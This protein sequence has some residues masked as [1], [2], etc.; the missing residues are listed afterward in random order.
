MN[1]CGTYT[2]IR[3]T[4]RNSSKCTTPPAHKQSVNKI[5]PSTA[6]GTSSERKHHWHHSTAVPPQINFSQSNISTLH[7]ILLHSKNNVMCSERCDLNT[8]R[9]NVIVNSNIS[10]PAR[11]PLLYIIWR[12]SRV[13][14]RLWME[15]WYRQHTLYIHTQHCALIH[16]PISLNYPHQ[17]FSYHCQGCKQYWN[18]FRYSY[19]RWKSLSLCSLQTTYNYIFTYLCMFRYIYTVL[20]LR[21]VH[22]SIPQY[23]ERWR[24][25]AR[26]GSVWVLQFRLS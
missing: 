10:T 23:D 11:S 24:S 1:G 20:R 6:D 19:I 16:R 13:I 12:A 5:P 18:G 21:T 15:H 25:F 17:A 7:K 26:Y 8:N 14:R 4:K 3:T 9:N 2:H 22:V